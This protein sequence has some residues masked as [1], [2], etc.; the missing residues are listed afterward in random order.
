MLQGGRTVK[1][2]HMVG[3]ALWDLNSFWE[4]FVQKLVYLVTAN[5][6]GRRVH[7]FQFFFR[8]AQFVSSCHFDLS[9]NLICFEQLRHV[10]K[11]YYNGFRE[12]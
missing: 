9:C 8:F 2:N 3:S 7:V 6:A 12:V 10:I 11:M 5:P 1:E 4:V